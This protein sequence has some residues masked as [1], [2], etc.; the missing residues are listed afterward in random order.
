M[1]KQMQVVLYD[2]VFQDGIW[3][4]VDCVVF[5]CYNDDG[6]FESNVMVEIDGIGDGKMVEF[7]DFGDGGDVFLEV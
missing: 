2:Y 3:G 7:K 1:F 6:I 5:G 4:N